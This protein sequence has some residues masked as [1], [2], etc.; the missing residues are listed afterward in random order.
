[1]DFFKVRRLGHKLLRVARMSP[2]RISTTLV[3][4]GGSRALGGS[5][6]KAVVPRTECLQDGR[7]H[8]LTGPG[9][10]T[11]PSGCLRVGFRNCPALS[12]RGGGRRVLS[13]D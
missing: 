10:S 2:P 12:C 6:V 9:G 8:R 13:T 3:G 7:R 4:R 11:D 5:R 1:M